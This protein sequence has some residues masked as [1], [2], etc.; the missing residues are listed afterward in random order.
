MLI[1]LVTCGRPRWASAIVAHLLEEAPNALIAVCDNG[2]RPGQGQG[3]TPFCEAVRFWQ[4]FGI[5]DRLAL[6]GTY[7]TEE[8]VPQPVP[9]RRDIPKGQVM[10]WRAPT[11]LGA[12]VGR[13]ELLR[14]RVPG[15]P[16]VRIDDDWLP[17]EHGWLEAAQ[18]ISKPNPRQPLHAGL[19][20]VGPDHKMEQRN[21]P[22]RGVASWRLPDCCGPIWYVAGECA[23][24]LGG[25]YTGFGATLLDDLEYSRRA[26]EWQRRRTMGSP[27]VPGG[28]GVVEFGWPV[29]DLC[30][31][32]GVKATGWNPP[33]DLFIARCEAMKSADFNLKV[34]L[35]QEAPGAEWRRAGREYKETR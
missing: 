20:R 6:F 17:R 35:A 19:V 12:G 11:N 9:R 30:T 13:N 10:V 1:T 29:R 8:T 33:W 28:A 24:A 14:L 25:F 5:A 7:R 27:A 2:T 23:D 26:V 3:D 16:F 34:P 15:E 22:A 31:D 18:R 4:H 21:P 32:S